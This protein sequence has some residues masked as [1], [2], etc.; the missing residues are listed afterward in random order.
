MSSSDTAAATAAD[1]LVAQVAALDPGEL[2][3]ESVQRLMAAAVTAYGRM[4][5]AGV[6]APAFGSATDVTA[7]DAVRAAS[8]VL[9]GVNLETFELALW[10]TWGGAP[11]TAPART[12]KADEA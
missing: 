8:A 6:G 4:L 9:K 3:P 5:D 12:E 1:D 11:W 10:E 2:A 7:T